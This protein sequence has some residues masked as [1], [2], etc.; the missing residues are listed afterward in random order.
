MSEQSDTYTVLAVRYGTRMTSRAEVFLH[1]ALYG[2]PDGPL[3][4]D[5][6]FWIVRNDRQTILVDCGFNEASGAARDRTMLVSPAEALS[7]LGVNPAQVSHVVLTHAHYDHI[8]NLALFPS[9]RFVVSRRELEFWTSPMGSKLLFAQSAEDD[10]LS[11]LAGLHEAGRVDL[12]EGRT[13]LLPGL[14]LV[15]VGGHTPGQLVVIVDTEATQVVLASDAVHYYEEIELDRP[16]AHVAD[17]PG[18]YA[19]F[20]LLR[21]LTAGGGRVLVAGHDPTVMERF[22]VEPSAPGLAA[23]VG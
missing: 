10:D 11:A 17:V 4:M 13:L 6:Y 3:A 14:E 23:R 21:D 5:Y 20:A 15:E 18:M 19:G 8:G 1:Y 2:E 7:Q 9:A 12:V 16:F 22:P